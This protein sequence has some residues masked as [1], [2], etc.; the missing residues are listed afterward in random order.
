[1]NNYPTETRNPEF[2]IGTE[3]VLDA[4][5]EVV[6][7][8]ISSS[9]LTIAFRSVVGMSPSEFISN[10]NVDDL[11]ARWN[12]HP[13]DRIAHIIETHLPEDSMPIEPHLPIEARLT[14]ERRNLLDRIRSIR[15]AIGPVSF[16]IGDLLREMDEESA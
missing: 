5:H 12:E 1:M 13:A 9:G 15:R 10:E 11:I 6:V 2:D 8:N 3:K 16:D 7:T 14:S 4:F